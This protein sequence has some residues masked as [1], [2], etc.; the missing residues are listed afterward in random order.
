MTEELEFWGAISP[1]SSHVIWNGQFREVVYRVPTAA[2]EKQILKLTLSYPEEERIFQEG[3]IRMAYALL[4][5][6][7]KKIADTYP[8]VEAR[9]SYID[10]WPATLLQQVCEQFEVAKAQPFQILKDLM[11]DPDFGD[12]LLSSGGGSESDATSTDE[13]S[14]P[15]NGPSS[16]STSPRTARKNR[17]DGPR[18]TRAPGSA[19]S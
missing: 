4:E 9:L 11:D 1:L 16:T 14:P 19:T 10:T 7:G 2:E 12:A 3:L 15:E 8:S 18:K 6:G 5:V 17:N 13:P